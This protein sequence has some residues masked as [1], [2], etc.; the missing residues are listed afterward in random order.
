[1]PM[2]MLHGTG[3]IDGAQETADNYRSCIPEQTGRGAGGSVDRAGQLTRSSWAAGRS[4]QGCGLEKW[5]DVT[6]SP[7]GVLS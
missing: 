5:V 3:E 6:V 2:R 7:V 4:Y 1:M